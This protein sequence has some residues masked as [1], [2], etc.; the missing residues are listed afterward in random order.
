MLVRATYHFIAHG[1]SGAARIRHSLS[2]L[3]FRAKR[4]AK[5]RAHRAA[6]MRTHTQL[7]SSATGSAE[8][9]P[10]DRLRRTIQYSRDTNDRTEKPRRTGCPA[11]AGHDSFV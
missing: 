6:R 1:T 10:D 2:P 9:P 5:P 11:F 8:W 4:Y 3:D 7:S